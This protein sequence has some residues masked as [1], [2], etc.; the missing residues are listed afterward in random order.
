MSWVGVCSFLCTALLNARRPTEPTR[1]PH[2]WVSFLGSQTTPFSYI[3][4][5]STIAPSQLYGLNTL[6]KRPSPDT[7]NSPLEIQNFANFGMSLEQFIRTSGSLIVKPNRG[8]IC[9]SWVDMTVLNTRLSCCSSTSVRT[10]HSP[11]SDSAKSSRANR[12]RQAI[13]PLKT[14]PLHRSIHNF[15]IMYLNI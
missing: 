15:Y 5:C 9:S 10:C 7:G 13:S 6:V 11:H 2:S 4:T 14:V 3:S 1:K 12:E 8:R